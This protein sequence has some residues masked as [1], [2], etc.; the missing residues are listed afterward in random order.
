[1]MWALA[2]CL[3]G[4][5]SAPLLFHVLSTMSAFTRGSSGTGARASVV[6]PVKSGITT[7]STVGS[8]VELRFT[9]SATMEECLAFE[10]K[11]FASVGRIV[12]RGKK[13][14][15]C[16]DLR[17]CQV[18]RP[19][20]S[21][22]IVKLMQTD[23]PNIVRNAFLGQDSALLYLQI[24]RFIFESGPLD[25]RRMFNNEAQLLAWLGEVT[26]VAEQTRLRTFLGSAPV[27]A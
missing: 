19:E 23:S 4:T 15:I 22:R 13:A 10:A 16:T 7:E 25:R 12:K 21:D 8:L 27:R 17:A 11:L 2:F 5:A 6:T 24:Q 26:S 14:I 20:V 1:M 9:G 3:T 18:F